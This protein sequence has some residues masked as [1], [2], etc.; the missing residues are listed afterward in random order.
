MSTPRFSVILFDW[1]DTVMRDDP[2]SFVPM[3]EWPQVHAIDGVVDVLA[4]LHADRRRCILATSAEISNESQIRAAL[5]RVGAGR[6]FERIYCRKN[7]GLPKGED[8]YRFILADLGIPASEALMIGDHF[9]ADVLAPNRL[10]I[11]AIWFNP[12][13]GETRRSDLH[14]TVHSMQ[15]L[16]GLVSG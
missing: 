13:T 1:G 6:Y 11:H 7:T 4:R 3:V 15:E 16:L 10:G 2:A 8:F 14:E 5:D 9:E 12:R